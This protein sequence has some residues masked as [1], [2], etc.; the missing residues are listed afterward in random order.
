M[1]RWSG[2]APGV[3][4]LPVAAAVALHLPAVLGDAPKST[5]HLRLDVPLPTELWARAPTTLFVCGSCFHPERK[6]E[7]LAF[8][9][10]GRSQT[11][12][13]H[14][15]PRLDPL[16]EL[17]PDLDV[18]GARVDPNSAEDPKLHA[19]ASGFWGF[20]DIP[21]RAPGSD[22]FQLE[23]R[24]EFDDGTSGVVV[25]GTIAVADRPV[26]ATK[27]PRER[28]GGP[29][30]LV[31]ICMATH[32]PPPALL[33]R[34]LRSIRE[35]TH[36]NWVCL[37]SDDCSRP[38]RF[39]ALEQAIGGDPRFIVSRSSRR[40][41]FYRNFE[42]V[43]AMVPQDSQYVALSDQDDFWHP[44]KV[45]TLLR[46][47]GSAQLVYSDARVV[48]ADGGLVSETYWSKRRNNH[49]DLLSLLVANSV[50]GAASLFRRELLDDAL[51]FPPAQFAHYHDHWLALTALTLG[52]VAY[53]DRP[54]YDYVQ[55]GT[56]T[57]GHAAAN[58][59]PSLRERLQS[60]RGNH[61][62]RVRLWRMHYFVDACRLLQIARILEFRG[63]ERIAAE[64]R[65]VLDRFLHAEYSLGSLATLGARGVREMV[66]TPETLG[67]EWMLF[68][69]FLWRRL[70]AASARELPRRRLRLDAVPPSDLAPRAG[71]RATLTSA[72]RAIA[73][74]IAPL[75]LALSPNAP[76][77]VNLLIP[78][79][80]LAHFFGG[81]IA[82]FNL[83]RR[84]SERG[85]RVRIVTVDPTGPLPHDWRATVESYDG[86]A[87][88][89]D[90]VE[91]AFG[92]ESV[93]LEVSATD[94]FIATTWWTAHIAANAGERLKSP[95]FVYLIQEYEPL[96]FPMGT[97]AALAAASYRFPHYGLFSS[98][99]LRDYFRQRGIG[100]FAP[101]GL[102]GDR[103]WSFRNAITD[104]GRPTV[105]EL[106]GRR[107]RRL[108]F[109]ARPEA[110]AA[111]NL[112]E[113]GLLALVRVFEQGVFDG[114]WEVNGIGTVNLPHQVA[115]GEGAD[116]NLLARSEQASYGRL[117]RNHDLGLALMYTPHP[118]LVPIE[119]A[120]AGMLTV[121]NSFENKTAPALSA[122]SRNLITVEPSIEAIAAGLMRAV[123]AC[124]DFEGRVRNSDVTWSRAW[125]I[126]FHDDL[127]AAIMRA[128]SLRVAGAT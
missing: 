106:K 41:D 64:R 70:L 117:L 99:L 77:R 56:A 116:L 126:S 19:Y 68:R 24:A 93:P 42:R 48:T 110:H 103:S 62:E 39:A 81:Y 96:T 55:H 34:Q 12:M 97:Y 57:L 66:G 59:M 65:R 118:S 104:V 2:P 86:L 105:G 52:R 38:E 73:A 85:A 98:E 63:G 94:R 79:I 91:V 84:L 31:A 44:D 49:T 89:F 114:G 87:G 92:R 67:G 95:P 8:V 128:L 125:D 30:P 17:H 124:N 11:V 1:H 4:R 122:I 7:R 14:G 47:I 26:S 40:L 45:A 15:M 100:V 16:H 10:D 127:V 82:K 72:A 50:T 54:L 120:S 88:L 123:S 18:Y 9:L 83:A 20:V 22:P 121:T 36:S 35:Q 46:E 32:D 6:V 71:R 37:I 28:T 5:L 58:Q 115:L 27:L 25:L 43:L 75:E 13:A 74:K 109:Y 60:S 21:A 78:T 51:P 3:A 112:F 53:V 76:E 90:R 119:M 102:G 111:R 23:L 29:G 61:R 113:L 80:D 33:E 108:L 107:T 101:D 69:A